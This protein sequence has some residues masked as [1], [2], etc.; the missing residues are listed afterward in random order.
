MHD[1][2][3]EGAKGRG[4]EGEDGGREGKGKGG[5]ERTED[6]LRPVRDPFHSRV[7]GDQT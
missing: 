6:R 1:G 2:G 3:G 7:N 5:G 4:E